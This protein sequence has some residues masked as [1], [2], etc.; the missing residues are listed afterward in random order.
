[1]KRVA[2]LS[3]A[4]L[5]LTSVLQP[6]VSPAASGG[7]RELLK[8][9]ARQICNAPIGRAPSQGA[10]LADRRQMRTRDGGSARMVSW[11]LDDGRKVEITR[12][13]TQRENSDFIDLYG[14][15]GEAEP[16]LRA[17]VKPDCRMEGG[18][19]IAYGRVDGRQAPIEILLLD[20]N[21]NPTGRSEGLNPP[22]PAGRYRACNR[23]GI[24]DNGVN[25]TNPRI[26]PHLARDRDGALV[27][28]DFW[29]G[30]S[31]PFDFGVPPVRRN[32]QLSL[33]RPNRHGS[34]VASVLIANAPSNSCIVPVRYAPFSKGE[35]VRE[36]V[37]FFRQAGV[38]IVSLQSSRPN[39]WPVFEQAIRAN[40]D[41]LFVVAAGNEGGDLKTRPLYPAVYDLPNILVVGA[42]DASGRMW[43]RSNRGRGIVDIA[44]NAVDVP[45]MRF[46]GDMA[47]LSG[48]SF[49]APKAAGFAA[50]LSGNRDLSGADLR[51]EMIAAARRSGVAADGIPVIPDGS[52][53]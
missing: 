22:V 43:E 49:A 13:R 15:G 34:L 12:I 24:L 29:D 7:D 52:I 25:Y 33:F 28:H 50:R 36:A 3:A 8:Q 48:T 9:V 44:V 40:P 45:V 47:N 4:L 16:L 42:V 53:R 31:R 46:G 14:K 32:P 19:E 17:Q 21:L 41:I 2:I 11:T 20:G 6:T 38:R 23:I 1:M 5:G 10:R 35:E 30:D 18:R 39:P 27:G 51:S 26:E 37:D